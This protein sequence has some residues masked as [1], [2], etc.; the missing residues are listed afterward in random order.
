VEIKINQMKK[1]TSLVLSIVFLLALSGAAIN[2]LQAQQTP[3]FYNE[4]Q[5]F[6]K[7]DSLHQPPKNAILFTGS[8]SFRLWTHVQDSF[9]GHTILNRAFGGATLPDVI[10]YAH[11]VIIPYKPKQVVIYCGDNDLATQDTTINGDSV[12]ARFITLFNS[13][14]SK[15]P[16]TSI[17]YVAIKPSP[18]RQHLLPKVELANRQIKD[19]LK[20]K[21]KTAFVDVY[22][23][24]LN[25]D[26]TPRKELFKEDMLHMNAQGYTIWT[27]ALRPYLIK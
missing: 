27:A 14:R 1:S 8:S 4:I 2:P 17:V 25:A 12:T 7:Q 16:N 21:K 15:L 5:A 3:P 6:K 13:I 22:H 10:R 23:K 11:D 26:G 20:Q 18:S 9:P 24:M 19:F